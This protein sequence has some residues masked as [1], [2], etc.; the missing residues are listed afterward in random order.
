MVLFQNEI[1]KDIES[2]FN[3]NYSSLNQI[4]KTCEDHTN[5]LEPYMSPL[6][7]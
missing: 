7:S 2:T 1:I 3:K 6:G 4:I 5:R